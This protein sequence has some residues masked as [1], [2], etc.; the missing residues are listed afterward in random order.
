MA[1]PLVGALPDFV[2]ERLRSDGWSGQSPLAPLDSV[3]QGSKRKRPK[4]ISTRV[5][6]GAPAPK[7][8]R[9]S[10]EI[11]RRRRGIDRDNPDIIARLRAA[12]DP[13]LLARV[14]RAIE[15]ARAIRCA[16]ACHIDP[17]KEI[18]AA[19]R[20]GDRFY[21]GEVARDTGLLD[22]FI[23]GKFEKESE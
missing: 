15:A 9:P 18:R 10:G 17:R 5:K 4:A 1:K 2:H 3:A 21:A 22:E 16:R 20:R 14:D 23:E 6:R 13:G 8:A 12:S 19:L 11:S 7:K